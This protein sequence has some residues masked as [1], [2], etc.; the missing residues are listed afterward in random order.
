VLLWSAAM[1]A[2]LLAASAVLAWLAA[3]VHDEVRALRG[4]LDAVEAL[5]PADAELADEIAV[6]RDRR[7]GSAAASPR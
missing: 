7:S 4:A 3:R 6:T 2:L 1:V 5:A